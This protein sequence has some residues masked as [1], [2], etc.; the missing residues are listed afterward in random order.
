[1]DIVV[2]NRV[3]FGINGLKVGLRIFVVSE[4]QNSPPQLLENEEY[5]LDSCSRGNV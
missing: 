5:N 1:M 2:L 3:S 4:Y